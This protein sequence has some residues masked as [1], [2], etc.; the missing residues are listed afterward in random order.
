MIWNLIH[1]QNIPLHS[2]TV[3]WINYIQSQRF[4][5]WKKRH[6]TVYMIPFPWSMRILDLNS[7]CEFPVSHM[8]VIVITVAISSILNNTFSLK[9]FTLISSQIDSWSITTASQVSWNMQ[10]MID[11]NMKLIK[12]IRCKSVYVWFPNTMLLFWIC[13]IYCR[14]SRCAEPANSTDNEEKKIAYV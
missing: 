2:I 7:R 11:C 8:A 9:N 6:S 5:Y 13:S 14:E 1:Q 4:Y 12:S 10:Q 3:N